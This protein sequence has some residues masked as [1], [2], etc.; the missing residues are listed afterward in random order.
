MHW[1]LDKWFYTGVHQ[2]TLLAA[3][4]KLQSILILSNLKGIPW[5]KQA[6]QRL[7]NAVNCKIVEVVAMKQEISLIQSTEIDAS[8]IP[9]CSILDNSSST[10]SWTTQVA[11]VIPSGRGRIVG[12]RFKWEQSHRNSCVTMRN[13]LMP[14]TVHFRSFNKFS[15]CSQATRLPFACRLPYSDSM[16]CA[17]LL[18]PS[19]TNTNQICCNSPFNVNWSALV[20][21][22]SR[23]LFS[24]VWFQRHS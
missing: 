6:Y 3:L 21:S 5:E 10:P 17:N 2:T 20:I 9:S 4:A 23:D 18:L 13:I 8:R 16:V 1:L 22:C 11:S 24:V 12:T 7:G 15:V 19:N 14:S